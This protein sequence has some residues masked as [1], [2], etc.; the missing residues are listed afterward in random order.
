MKIGYNLVSNDGYEEKKTYHRHRTRP[1][2][3]S[4]NG[5]VE[6]RT[7]W[8]RILQSRHPSPA[9]QL[10]RGRECATDE[11]PFH[12]EQGLVPSHSF[13]RPRQSQQRKPK[14]NVNTDSDEMG[15]G[16][17]ELRE[18]PGT[19]ENQGRDDNSETDGI[20]KVVL[21]PRK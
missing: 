21:I 2:S 18:Q 5:S 4:Q 15:S 12:G 6:W 1:P 3:T 13:E 7:N 11:F 19:K 10:L 9:T 20:R 14:K 17:V 16:K 8:Q